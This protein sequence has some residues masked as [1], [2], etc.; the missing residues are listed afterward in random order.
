MKTIGTIALALVGLGLVTTPAVAGKKKS[1]KKAA[2]AVEAPR[3]LTDAMGL[4]AIKLAAPTGKKA[5]V[6]EEGA[7]LAA[8]DAFD[9]G[10]A[11]AADMPTGDDA[12]RLDGVRLSAADAGEVVTGNMADIEYCWSRVPAAKRDA[13]ETSLRFT[14]D[15]RG[16]VL[17]FALD[18]EVPS[19]FASCMKAATKRWRFPI[20]D[21]ESIVE[22]P[23]S[24]R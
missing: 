13:L 14:V 21:G 24:L 16:T 4:D 6:I 8:A 20:A 15:P 2:V 12:M 7:A 19:K 23:L 22:Y 1:K 3:R 9:L 5:I 10:L 18:G 11:R 17:A